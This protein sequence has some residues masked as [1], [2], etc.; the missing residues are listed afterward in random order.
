MDDAVGINGEGNLDL[1]DAAQGPA[2]T[3]QAEPA[4]RFVG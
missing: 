1:R 3:V 2:D 4:E